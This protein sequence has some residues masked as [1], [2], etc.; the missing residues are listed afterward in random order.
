MAAAGDGCSVWLPA[1]VGVCPLLTNAIAV[2]NDVCDGEWEEGVDLPRCENAFTTLDAMC[3]Q[4]Y[5]KDEVVAAGGIKIIVV[6]LQT[7][8]EHQSVCVKAVRLL[9]VIV[10]RSPAFSQGAIDIGGID[11]VASCMRTHPTDT[12]VECCCNVLYAFA[13]GDPVNKRKMVDLGVI[14]LCITGMRAYVPSVTVCNS[15]CSLLLILSTYESHAGLI[16][17]AH[18]INAVVSAMTTHADDASLMSTANDTLNV[19][20]LHSPLRTRAVV[21]A[22]GVKLIITSMRRFAHSTHSIDILTSACYALNNMIFVLGGSPLA[23]DAINDGV[24]EA[25]VTNA[26]AEDDIPAVQTL[27]LRMLGSDMYGQ[28][29][30]RVDNARNTARMRHLRCFCARMWLLVKRKRASVRVDADP[31][32]RASDHRAHVHGQTMRGRYLWEAVFGCG[33]VAL[34]DEIQ[35]HIISFIQ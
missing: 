29:F 1:C 27:L 22:G 19:I 2:L 7:H 5:G 23:Q 13:W 16:Y 14:E 17:D 11:A 6:L 12:S 28:C 10:R 32:F 34:A 24:I 3:E 21:D 9:A 33:G 20:A 15:T 25:A 31:L 26:D 4:P 30:I 8:G 18:G 35:R